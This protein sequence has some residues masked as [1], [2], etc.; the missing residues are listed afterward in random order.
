MAR[1]KVQ[2]N[3]VGDTKIEVDGIVGTSCV[4][5]TQ[6]VEAALNG[7]PDNREYKPE[8]NEVEVEQGLEN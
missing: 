3:K 2:I 7:T 8:Y 1:I 4:S 5:M 6:A